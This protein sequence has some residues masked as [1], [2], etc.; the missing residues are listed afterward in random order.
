MKLNFELV[1]FTVTCVAD[2]NNE[3]M[4]ATQFGGL[5]CCFL[6]TTNMLSN[7]AMRFEKVLSAMIQSTTD[8]VNS[9]GDYGNINCE[10]KSQ[11]SYIVGLRE[12]RPSCTIAVL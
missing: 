1:N 9:S 2:F 5:N 8:W 4:L 3:H 11:H 12:R 10:F 7:L 6:V